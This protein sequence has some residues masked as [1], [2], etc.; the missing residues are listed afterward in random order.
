MA[1]QILMPRLGWNMEEGTLVEWLKQ[2]GDPVRAGDLVCIIEGDK[3]TMEIESFETGILRIPPASPAPGTTVPVGTLLGYVVPEAELAT[4]DPS[5]APAA[6][7]ED[8]ASRTER[9]GAASPAAAGSPRRANGPA[10][11]P[12]AR[13]AARELGVDW[14]MLKGSGR[15]GRIVERD[16]RA[17]AAASAGAAEPSVPMSRLRRAIAE[18][19]AAAARTA[20]PVTLTTEADAT[21]LVRLREQY[22]HTSALV[23]AY[24][25]LLVKLTGIALAEHPALNATLADDRI[26]RHAHIHIGIAVD[27]EH[28]LVAPVIRDV[29]SKSVEDIARVSARLIEEARAGRLSLDR[30]Q[31]GTFTLTNLGMYDIDAFT[32]IINLPECAILGVGRIVPRVVVIDEA[33]AT[34]GI[35]K[36]MSLSLT[37]DHRIVDGGPAARFLQRVKQLIEDPA[38]HP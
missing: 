31:D 27:T 3:A 13:R 35:R 2:E 9:A 20:A 15:T 24:H 19:M 26:I 6:V 25:D 36:M 16:V 34:T 23:P 12:R 7:L 29:P 18:R 1:Y 4:F 8:T 10:A 14:R 37:F 5:A 21:A 17:A 11:S 33:T 32:P 22:R 30:L 38:W 28:G